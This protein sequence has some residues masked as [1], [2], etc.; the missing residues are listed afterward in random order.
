MTF[1]IKNFILTYLDFI[2]VIDFGYHGYIHNVTEPKRAK[3]DPSVN[4][5]NFQVQCKDESYRGVSYDKDLH[6]S[7][8]GA[9]QKKSPVKIMNA[10]TRLSK[11]KSKV[12]EMVVNHTTTVEEIANVNFPRV[13]KLFDDEEE[14]APKKIIKDILTSGKKNQFVSL[15]GYI[16]I[17]NRPNMTIKTRN[18][19]VQKR[20][21]T[22]NDK[23][24]VAKLSLW[25]L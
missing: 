25:D 19:P 21:V 22:V 13:T 6:E 9:A 24:G 4:Y 23:S 14:V 2:P 17:E 8:H 1:V 16:D 18:G 11:G 10:R 3:T 20:D 12:K 5:F 7:F 15:V